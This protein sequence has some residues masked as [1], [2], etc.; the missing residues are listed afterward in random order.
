M[1]YQKIN[2]CV[3]NCIERIETKSKNKMNAYSYISYFVKRNNL[4]MEEDFYIREQFEKYVNKNSKKLFPV[5]I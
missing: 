1:N 5:G 4:T 3:K 2:K